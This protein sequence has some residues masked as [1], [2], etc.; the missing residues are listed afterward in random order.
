MRYLHAD[1]SII[2]SKKHLFHL[3]IYDIINVDFYVNV[4]ALFVIIDI[5]LSVSAGQN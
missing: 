2:K 1:L 3:K 5:Y 4:F